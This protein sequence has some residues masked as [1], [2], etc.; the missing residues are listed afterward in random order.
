M[1][2][3][4]KRYFHLVVLFI[5]ILFILIFAFGGYKIIAYSVQI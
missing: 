1:T 2:L 4:F 5:A 3:K